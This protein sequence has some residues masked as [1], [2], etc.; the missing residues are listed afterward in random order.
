MN[1]EN[2]TAFR[3]NLH[4]KKRGERPKLIAYLSEMPDGSLSGTE[5]M[6]RQEYAR[7]QKEMKMLM[8]IEAE[9]LWFAQSA[10]AVEYR[11]R[12]GMLKTVLEHGRWLVWEEAGSRWDKPNEKPKPKKK[13]VKKAVS[14]K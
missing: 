14:K 9:G 13:A 3:N 8:G 2:S 4:W 12:R 10:P 6:T 1:I 7:R 11:A 5:K